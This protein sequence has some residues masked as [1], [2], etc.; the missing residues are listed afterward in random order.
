MIRKAAQTAKELKTAQ[1]TVNNLWAA[2][3]KADKLAYPPQAGGAAHRAIHFFAG[4]R[5]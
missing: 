3:R 1:K 2:N 4:R 5:I